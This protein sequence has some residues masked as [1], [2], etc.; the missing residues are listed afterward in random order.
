MLAPGRSAPLA[1]GALLLAVYVA[2]AAPTVT[3]WDAGEFI[4]AVETLGIPHPPGTPLYVLLARVWSDA[5]GFLPRAFA[6]NLFSA[7]ATAAAVAMLAALLV[8]PGSGDRERRT[9]AACAA[10]ICAGATATVWSNATETEVYAASLALSLALLLVAERAGRATDARWH[11]L[12]GYLFALAVALHMSALVAI[13][14]AV[15]FASSDASGRFSKRAA[16]GVAGAGITAAGAGTVSL[17]VMGFGLAMIAGSAFLERSDRTAVSTRSLAALVIVV[18]LGLSAT[19]VMVVRS[20]HDPALDSGNPETWGALLEVVGRRQYA[21]AGLWPRQAPLWI[22]AGNVVEYLD[23]Q[24]AMGL[25]ADVAPSW[26]RTPITLLFALLGVVGCIGHARDDR[27]SWLALATVF[28]SATV[29]LVVYMNFKAGASYAWSFIPESTAHEVRERD[30][31]FALGFFIWGAWAGYGAVRWLSPR[32]L[33]WLG[34]AVAC[35]PIVLNW[36]ITN[37]RREPEALLARAAAQ[38]WLLP[39][40]PRTVLVTGGDND[41]FPLWYLQ[42]VEG[43]RPDV[44]IVTAPL[45]GA[46][47]Y[48]QEIARR[49]DLL[50]RASAGGQGDRL[51]RLVAA[52][53]RL[54]RPVAISLTVDPERRAAIGS[55]LRF[56]GLVFRPDS[57]GMQL[58]PAAAAR[59]AQ[60]IPGVVLERDPLDTPDRAPRFIARVL[61]CPSLVV[62]AAAGEVPIASLD[63]TCNFR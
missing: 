2:T 32:R 56:D 14:G 19:V 48:R 55:E 20:A 6:T 3:L 59:V 23:W 1:A 21:P 51:R 10:A 15:L 24:F 57:S 53:E 50:P 29:G 34:L 8:R 13:P 63:S 22:Q 40:A 61:G 62:R 27:R 12:L 46:A 25:D 28:V 7:A 42:L 35:A 16:L 49:T 26:R 18:A 54:G 33:K 41:S 58:D 36:R 45:L 47:W 52:A 17:P 30:Y 43:V 37:R 60:L 4:A 44:T 11:V 31:F 9:L 39:L 5:L 38:A